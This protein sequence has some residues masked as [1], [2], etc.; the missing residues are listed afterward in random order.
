MMKERSVLVLRT[1]GPDL[2]SHGGF[3][4]HKKGKVFAPDWIDNDKCGNGLHGWLWGEGDGDMGNINPDAAW[5]VVRVAEKDLRHGK[6]DL[7]GKCKFKA[8][9]V[10]HCG[11]KESATKYIAENGAH[12]KSIIGYTA[13]AGDGGTATAGDCGTATAGNY[14]TAT[15]GNYGTATAGNYG[16]AT[17]GN[18]GTATAGYRGTAT[19][20]DNGIISIR[21]FDN[22]SQRYRIA[23][24]YIG[25]NGIERNK[26]YRLNNQHQF[27]EVR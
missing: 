1:C 23:I 12:G 2:K 24:A 16:T 7:I 18:Y 17:A 19:A 6:G 21:Y 20:G 15:A 10:I 26:K 22:K 9:I 25:E 14:G 13:T 4:W 5:L 3:Q 27:E 11:N 8:G